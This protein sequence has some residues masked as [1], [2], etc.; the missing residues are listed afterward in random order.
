MNKVIKICYFT[1]MYHR[2]S[3]RIFFKEYLS[4]INNGF[5]DTLVVADNKRNEIKNKVKIIDIKNNKVINYV[6]KNIPRE[7]VGKPYSLSWLKTLIAKLIVL[8]ERKI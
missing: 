7:V 6:H 1:S 3:T 8:C 2:S 4:L 5:I